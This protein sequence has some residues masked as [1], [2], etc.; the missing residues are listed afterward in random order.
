MSSDSCHVHSF[1]I[2]IYG[3]AAVLSLFV[4]LIFAYTVSTRKYILFIIF[5]CLRLKTES[6]RTWNRTNVT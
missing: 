2:I 6:K 4:S 5:L 1:S 3:F